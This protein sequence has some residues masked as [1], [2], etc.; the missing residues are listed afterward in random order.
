MKRH[1]IEM[2][3]KMRKNTACTVFL[4]TTTMIAEKIAMMEK[5]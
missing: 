4:E 5:K 1:A 2:K 3:S